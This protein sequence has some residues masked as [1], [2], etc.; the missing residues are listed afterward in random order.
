MEFPRKTLTRAKRAIACSPFELKLFTQMRRSSVSL[1][2]ISGDCGYFNQYT[3]API[4]ELKAE[5]SL[6]WLIRVGVLRREVDGQGLTDSF[7][8][9]PLGRQ[10]LDLWRGSP[11]VPRP[12]WS[13]RL[14]NL[15]TQAVHLAF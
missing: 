12:T 6:L 7:R 3:R 15:W 10:V 2:E 8:L 9:T 1:A 13:D 4:P 11:A 5:Q 14:R